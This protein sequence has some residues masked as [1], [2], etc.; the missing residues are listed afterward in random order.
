MSLLQ[1][2]SLITSAIKSVKTGQLPDLST[3]VTALAKEGILSKDEA[4]VVKAGLSMAN[5][6]ETGTKPNLPIVSN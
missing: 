5:G 4:V 3:T 6:I 1:S 2:T